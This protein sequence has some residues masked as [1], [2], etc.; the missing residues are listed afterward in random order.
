M[1]T[2]KSESPSVEALGL[3]FVN[4]PRDRDSITSNAALV[5]R[6]QV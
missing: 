1:S 2:Q 5:R 6:A 4:P 3:S